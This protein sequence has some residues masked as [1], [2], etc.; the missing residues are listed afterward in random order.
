MG[1]VSNDQIN[2]IFYDSE[3]G[4]ELLIGQTEEVEVVTNCEDEQ[5]PKY[6]LLLSS[7]S[8]SI[9]INIK[10][11]LYD[12]SELVYLLFGMNHWLC[13]EIDRL[14]KIR[15]RTKNKRIKKKLEKRMFAEIFK[16]W[17]RSV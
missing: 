16:E 11:P 2:V 8:G 6:E 17:K 5:K 9:D 1:L 13:K 4:K 14:M 12:F 15:N 10:K 3:T 7:I